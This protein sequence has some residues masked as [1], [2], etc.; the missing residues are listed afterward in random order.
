MLELLLD[1]GVEVDI[2]NSFGA[3]PL[4]YA[5]LRQHHIAVKALVARGADASISG[6]SSL[7]NYTAR[8]PKELADLAVQEASAIRDELA[9]LT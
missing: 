6:C 1:A 2:Q 4:H 3:T 5:V 7:W 8:T 9:Q